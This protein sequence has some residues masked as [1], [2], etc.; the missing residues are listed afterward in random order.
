MLVERFVLTEIKIVIIIIIIIIICLPEL[1]ISVCAYSAYIIQL[2]YFLRSTS[3]SSSAMRCL[4]SPIQA[5]KLAP[6]I[7]INSCHSSLELNLTPFVSWHRLSND[8]SV[9][10][11]HLS[12]KPASSRFHWALCACVHVALTFAALIKRHLGRFRRFCSVYS[13]GQNRNAESLS[14][15]K[16]PQRVALPARRQNRRRIIN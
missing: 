13:S 15:R 3:S 11:K 7:H 5:L 2:A 10:N 16:T 14:L 1:A 6:I 4:C 9:N 8:V 12:Q